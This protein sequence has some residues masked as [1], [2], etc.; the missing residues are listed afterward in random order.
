MFL[1]NII[2]QVNH[3]LQVSTEIKTIW[4]IQNVFWKAVFHFMGDRF[5]LT[6][7]R[8]FFVGWL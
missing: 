6:T 7:R 5:Y 3:A 2:F 8:N 1:S 4:K